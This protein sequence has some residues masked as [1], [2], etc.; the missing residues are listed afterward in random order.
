MERCCWTRHGFDTGIQKESHKNEAF[1]ASGSHSRDHHVN[2]TI[3]SAPTVETT[4]TMSEAPQGDLVEVEWHGKKLYLKKEKLDE[5]HAIDSNEQRVDYVNSHPEVRSGQAIAVHRINRE[6]ALQEPDDLVLVHWSGTKVG[7]VTAS[8]RC[9]A[10]TPRP[11]S[12]HLA[13][14]TLCQVLLLERAQL[15]EWYHSSFEDHVD[16]VQKHPEA[17]L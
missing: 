11:S 16:F 10:D 15:D 13:L 2:T 4:A 1:G 8:V 3:Q 5:W 7:S 17:Q 12:H 9:N 6:R 14:P